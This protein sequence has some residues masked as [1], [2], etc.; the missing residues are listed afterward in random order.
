SA[1][2]LNLN[3]IGLPGVPGTPDLLTSS[4]TGSSNTDNKTSVAAMSFSVSLEGTGSTP[5]T[6]LELW[7]Q[8]RVIASKTLTTTDLLLPSVVISLDP[9]VSKLVDGTV[10]IAS[11]VNFPVSSTQAL[12]SDLSTPLQVTLDGVAPAVNGSTSQIPMASVYNPGSKLSFTLNFTEKVYAASN[13]QLVLTWDGLASPVGAT[14][15][16]TATSAVSG[17]NTLTYTYTVKDTDKANGF[18][19]SSLQGVT[20]LAGNAVLPYTMAFTAIVLGTPTIYEGGRTS[21]ILGSS[22]HGWG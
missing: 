20:D 3:L 17:V 14:L 7:A 22:R 16:S 21:G 19:V 5:G 9:S 12:S 8:N 10:A 13:S 11:K 15:V 1:T 18:K 2:A 4:D 6:V